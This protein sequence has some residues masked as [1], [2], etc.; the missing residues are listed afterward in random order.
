ILGSG[1]T[2]TGTP[3]TEGALNVSLHNQHLSTLRHVSRRRIGAALLGRAYLAEGRYVPV[4]SLWRA[5]QHPWRMRHAQA[6]FLPL[7]CLRGGL[8]RPHWHGDGAE[9]GTAPRVALLYVPVGHRPHGN[10]FDAVGERNRHHAKV[11]MVRA[12]SLA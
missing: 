3:R 11:R 9:K 1:T 2:G 8:H 12:W 10:L 5:H 4:L 6:R 7:P